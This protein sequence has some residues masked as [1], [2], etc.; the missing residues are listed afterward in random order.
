MSKS[1]Q[2]PATLFSH[3]IKF[4]FM[5]SNEFYGISKLFLDLFSDSSSKTIN[6]FDIH[7]FLKFLKMW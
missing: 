3:I 6:S 2:C 5:K 4:F 1:K 7:Q